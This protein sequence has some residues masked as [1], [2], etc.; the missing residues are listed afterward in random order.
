MLSPGSLARWLV[1]SGLLAGS[2][3]AQRETPNLDRRDPPSVLLYQINWESDPAKKLAFLEEFVTKF[4]QDQAIGWVYE[5]MYTILVE[6]NQPDRAL[7][8]AEKLLSLDPS[9][10]Q[11]AYNSLKIAEARKDPALAQKWSQVAAATAQRLLAAPGGPQLDF[12]RQVLAYTEYLAY[13]AILETPTGPLKLERMEQFLKSSPGSSYAPAVERLYLACLR[14]SDPAKAVSIAE[15]IV[16]GDRADPETLL[17]VAE[18]YA[19]KD[20]EPDKVVA[21]A[22]R[23]IALTEHD[24]EADPKQKPALTGHANW[25]IGS[26]SMQ[27]NKFAQADKSIRIALPYLRS[28]PRLL[29]RALFYLGWANYKLGN[30]ND[31]I[32]FT[33]DCTHVTGPFQAQSVKN[34][35]VIRSENPGR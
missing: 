29:S 9:D 22:T 11:L 33:Q 18:H 17:L 6:S 20:R 13:T 32:R 10:L 16:A 30:I 24:S 14:Q 12:A 27:Q 8:V 21:Y 23:A 2:C 31:A 7:G 1:V 5:R 26:I 35:A 25:L 4:P 3:L 28:D 19:R 15:Q 34:L